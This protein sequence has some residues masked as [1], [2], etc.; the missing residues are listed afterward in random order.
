MLSNQRKAGV[1]LNYISISL[2]MLIGIAYTP[3][4]IHMLGQS[5]YGIY[6]LAASIIAYLTVLD[7]GF[8]N[9][10]VRYTSQFIAE[11]KQKEQEEMFGMFLI[12]YTIIGF[13]SL[14]L[15]VVLVFNIEHLF[16]ANMTSNEVYRTKIAVSLMTLNL[17][18]TFPLSIWGSIMNA[19]EQF[20]FKRLFTIARNVLNPLAMIVLLMYGYKAIGLI[21][22]ITIF[23]VLSLC[24]DWLFCK[25][26]LKIK[27]RY[28]KFKWTF[29]KEVFVYS[30]WIFFNA[31]I[32]R[33][34]WSTGQFVL[35]IVSGTTAVA[36]YAVAV[37]LHSI[38]ISFSTAVSSVF[39]PKVT[40]M[41]VKG[42]NESEISDLFIKTGR[43]QYIV[44]G[45]I[46][47]SFILFGR[48]FIYY[49][50]G[51]E[52]DEAYIIAVLFFIPLVVP[53][54]QTLGLTILQAKNEMKFRS[55][56][57]LVIA[58]VSFALYFP[59]SN[60]Y[61]GTGCAIIT[62][63]AILVGHGFVMNYY[64]Y[65]KQKINI[66]LFWKEILSMSVVPILLAISTYVLLAIFDINLYHIKVYILTIIIY[67]ILY[68][69][70]SWFWS[71]NTFERKLIFNFYKS[72]NSKIKC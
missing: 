29:L 68:V 63:V 31:I 65:Y 30:L 19:Y 69:Y 18:I 66:P 55:L 59:M 5:E 46:L 54:I 12:L 43:L 36:I 56:V 26:R 16:S 24:A 38:F 58:I 53:L 34:Y 1:V 51:S 11:G 8:G 72:I 23:N 49:W 17:A 37:Q 22:V 35:G 28:G 41:V 52:Y 39:L 61:G 32:D 44:I 21:V 14:F 13:V 10:I 4:L 67:C 50:A 64:Y 70:M 62:S 40:S 71:F 7:L 45:F 33:V 3:F 15:G 20:V 25:Y 2:N 47:F 6:S 9:A 48:Q 60:Y 27:V 57:Y 42:S